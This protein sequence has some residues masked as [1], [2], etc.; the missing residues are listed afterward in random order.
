MSEFDTNDGSWQ[1]TDVPSAEADEADAYEQSRDITDAA[2]DDVIDVP[3]GVNPADAVEQQRE[4]DVDDE[5]YD[6]Y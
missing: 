5:A 4:V 1:N 2:D 6:D 3:D